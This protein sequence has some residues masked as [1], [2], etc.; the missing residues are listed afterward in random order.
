LQMRD[1][2]L[3][4]LTAEVNQFA[5]NLFNVA[6]TPG[7]QTT[8]SG[9]GAT[10][11]ANHIFAGVNIAAGVDNAATIQVNPDLLTNPALLDTGVGGPDP[12][13]AQTLSSNLQGTATFAAAGTLP[14]TTTSLNSYVGQIIGSAASAASAATS[15]AQD[16]SALLTQMQSQYTSETG[17]N[18]DSEL[19]TLIIYQNAYS[20]SARVI[21]TI[22]SMYDALMNISTS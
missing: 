14:A 7:L 22:Q 4:D 11:D 8:N 1:T 16:Q 5:N 9:L 20:A 2:A 19:S 15:N 18:L 13:I 12:S 3:P 21:S 6:A 17:V 10:N